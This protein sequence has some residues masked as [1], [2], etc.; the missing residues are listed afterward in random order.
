MNLAAWDA[1]A[2]VRRD[3]LADGCQELPLLGGDAEKSVVRELACLVP[4]VL[5]SA[6]SADPAAVL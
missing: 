3:A 6:E 5:T 4:D 2:A 1:S